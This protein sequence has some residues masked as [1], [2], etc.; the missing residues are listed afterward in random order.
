MESRKLKLVDL[1]PSF[2][3]AT[4]PE[5]NSTPAHEPQGD[6][7]QIGREQCRP[8]GLRVSDWQHSPA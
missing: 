5:P 8:V 7:F 2:R 1:I 6:T 3:I 4:A